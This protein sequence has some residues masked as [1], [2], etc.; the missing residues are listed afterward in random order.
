MVHT[1]VILLIYHFLPI[2][3]IL[4]II[5]LLGNCETLDTF[6]LICVNLHVISK[7]LLTPSVL[8]H[9]ILVPYVPLRV[10]GSESVPCFD[11]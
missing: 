2:Y 10:S 6:H 5:T 7:V 11:M 4:Y 1:L 8:W 9:R 3:G